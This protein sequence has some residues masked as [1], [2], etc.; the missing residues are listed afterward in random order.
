MA[1]LL[2]LFQSHYDRDEGA[3]INSH[4]SK[5]LYM[6]VIGDYYV[7]KFHELNE[8]SETCFEGWLFG[9]N[10]RDNGESV[11]FFFFRC[12]ANT[13]KLLSMI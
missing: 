2:L 13:L 6:G 8:S 4:K 7:C 9:L 5:I 11:V 12:L 3:Q 1:L 10:R